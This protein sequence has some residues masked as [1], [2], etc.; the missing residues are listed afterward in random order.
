[1]LENQITFYVDNDI[2]SLHTFNF[3]FIRFN[4]IVQNSEKFLI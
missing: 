1:M 4:C 2:L 3:N